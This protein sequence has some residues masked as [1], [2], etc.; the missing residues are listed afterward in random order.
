MENIFDISSL[1]AYDEKE[2]SNN[3]FIRKVREHLRFIDIW[4]YYR[5]TKL[6]KLKWWKSQK[7]LQAIIGVSKMPLLS[8]VKG[9]NFY[10]FR[11]PITSQWVNYAIRSIFQIIYLSFSVIRGTLTRNLTPIFLFL[12]V[13]RLLKP[14]FLIKFYTLLRCS[15]L[16]SIY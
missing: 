1:K 8:V 12:S 15:I 13:L 7:F 11:Y 5:W 16:N 4:L 6:V 10:L 2:K 9:S 14:I 3:T